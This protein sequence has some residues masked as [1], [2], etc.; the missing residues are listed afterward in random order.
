MKKLSED[1]KNY[2]KKVASLSEQSYDVVFEGMRA[3]AEKL[4]EKN[5]ASADAHLLSVLYATAQ[6]MVESGTPGHSEIGKTVMASLEEYKSFLEKYHADNGGVNEEGRDITKDVLEMMPDSLHAALDEYSKG[7]TM[8]AKASKIS[9][10]L[11]KK[12]Q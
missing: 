9:K 5:P 4:E 10:K 2:L 3:F 12:A 6:L 8:K 1:Q 11:N 7:D